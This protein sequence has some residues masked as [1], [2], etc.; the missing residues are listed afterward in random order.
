MFPDGSTYEGD[1]LETDG[2]KQRHGSGIYSIGTERY[3]GEWK[4]DAMN[5]QGKYF[6]TSGSVYEGCFVNNLFEGYGTYSFPDGVK[7]YKGYWRNNKMH[8]S[9][10]YVDSKNISF[11]GN[12]INGTFDPRE[13]QVE[14]KIE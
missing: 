11:Q 8:G 1:W 3:V 13:K 14:S 7:A 4:N 9:G 10:E 5:G 12:F 6:F 2:N